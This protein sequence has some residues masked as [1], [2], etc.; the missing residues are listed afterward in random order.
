[1][2]DKKGWQP[3]KPLRTV[4]SRTRVISLQCWKKIIGK[5]KILTQL[6]KR[7]VVILS[8]F[9]LFSIRSTNFHRDLVLKILWSPMTDATFGLFLTTVMGKRGQ[10]HFQICFEWVS[11]AMKSESFFFFNLLSLVFCH[12][13]R[14]GMELMQHLVDDACA[15]ARTFWASIRSCFFGGKTFLTCNDD[16]L[17]TVNI[18]TSKM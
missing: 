12:K 5:N 14:P 9:L 17:K 3:K 7:F 15:C 10:F 11:S 2:E 13:S 18:L 8:T 1:M 6:E 16:N 4:G